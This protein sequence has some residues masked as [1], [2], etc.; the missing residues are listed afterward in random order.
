MG[1][2]NSSQNARNRR[3]KSVKIADVAMSAMGRF[4]MGA[5]ELNPL[6]E[7]VSS[8]ILKN[9]LDIRQTLGTANAHFGTI[10]Y[11]FAITSPNGR[12]YNN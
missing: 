1:D 10:L 12:K 8:N 4:S 9:L 11:F 2:S 7:K 3:N 6:L 5:M